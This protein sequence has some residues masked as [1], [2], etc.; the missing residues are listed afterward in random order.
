MN[1][2]SLWSEKQTKVDA[3]KGISVVETENVPETSGGCRSPSKTFNDEDL[4]GTSGGSRSSS[5]MSRVQ[6]QLEEL[7]LASC[8]QQNAKMYFLQKENEALYQKLE[9]LHVSFPF[10]HIKKMISW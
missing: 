6:N 3:V 4:P 7:S 8:A 5:S 9:H 2:C 10:E 1:H